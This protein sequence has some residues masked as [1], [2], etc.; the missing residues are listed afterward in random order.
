MSVP[1]LKD[2]NAQ[3]E[4]RYTLIRTGADIIHRLVGENLKLFAAQEDSDTWKSYLDYLDEIIVDGLFECVLCS[5]NFLIFNTDPTKD[6]SPFMMVKLE[7]HAPEISFLPT[8]DTDDPDGF[9]AIVEGLVDD[10]FKVASLIPRVAKHCGQEMY[11]SDV[12]EIAELSDIRDE[13]LSRV[14]KGINSATDYRETF[15]T[16]SYLWIDDKEE[17]MRQFL[18]YGHMLTAEEIE[19]V[20]I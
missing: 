20:S 11:H 3:V 6:I 10:V 13:L 18:L 8:L 16:Y 19:Q 17:F 14:Q 5:L 15:N 1:P 7:L 12:D 9:Y 4:P 2:R